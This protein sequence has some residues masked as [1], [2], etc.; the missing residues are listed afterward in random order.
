MHFLPLSQVIV[1]GWSQSIVTVVFDCGAIDFG[2]SV[3]SLLFWQSGFPSHRK[4][5]EQKSNSQYI[6]SIKRNEYL[7]YAFARRASKFV[8]FTV[9]A[10]VFTVH[11]IEASNAIHFAVA[12]F[13]FNEAGPRRRAEYLAARVTNGATHFVRLILAV[14]HSIAD[15]SVRNADTVAACELRYVAR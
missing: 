8:G 15:Q 4:L 13:F 1:D 9:V 11:F 7:R 6:N 5:Y 3:S 10:V 12:Y 14:S 2:Q